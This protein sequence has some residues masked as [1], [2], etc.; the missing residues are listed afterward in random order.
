MEQGEEEW[1]YRCDNQEVGSSLGVGWGWF[2]LAS[3]V[4][5][6]EE[7]GERVEWGKEKEQPVDGSIEG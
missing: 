6:G 5:Q 2:H 4:G 7:L 1:G 3:E